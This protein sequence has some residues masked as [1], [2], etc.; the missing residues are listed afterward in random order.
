MGQDRSN[1]SMAHRALR[2][3]GEHADLLFSG[4]VA[5][6]IEAS[7][8]NRKALSALNAA[9][10]VY[11]VGEDKFR[12]TE[13]VRGMLS[14][15]DRKNRLF[16]AD[17]IGGDFERF[18]LLLD[19]F[20]RQSIEG[21]VPGA[22]I[23]DELTDAIHAMSYGISS[24]IR[25]FRE[26]IESKF[27]HVRGIEAKRRQNR[28]AFE[29][30]EALLGLLNHLSDP[31]MLQRVEEWH[32]RHF[33]P[34]Y[35]SQVSLKLP[36]WRAGLHHAITTLA[37]FHHRFRQ[38]SEEL[39]AFRAFGRVIRETPDVEVT[40]EPT[41][42]ECN[43]LNAFSGFSLACGV[44]FE[45]P[46][47]ESSLEHNARASDLIAAPRRRQRQMGVYNPSRRETRVDDPPHPLAQAASLLRLALE[48]EGGQINAAAYY[49]E[50]PQELRQTFTRL[51]FVE[52]MNN[53]ADGLAAIARG[54]IRHRAVG[55]R[56]FE[57]GA[58]YLVSDVE[59]W[60]EG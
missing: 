38:I 39:T 29:S 5:R 28:F 30:A 54:K 14:A 8:E 4:Y 40:V 57:M 59:L 49:D 58:N 56:A 31:A 45:D 17:S 60:T 13:P 9:S 48:S 42:A 1:Q 32:A 6:H 7:A 22:E 2:L 15:A 41:E 18:R 19:E 12:L 55:E 51:R 46:E 20:E 11:A 16:E 37:E 21:E 34:D 43:L 10:M 50:L 24:R 27:S 26:L 23:V 36:E 52:Q 33:A 44:N 35:R 53:T 47:Q 3:G 25:K